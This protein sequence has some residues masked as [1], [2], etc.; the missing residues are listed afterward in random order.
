MVFAAAE[1]SVKCEHFNRNFLT[2]NTEE[3][4]GKQHDVSLYGAGHESK[5]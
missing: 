1:F 5:I 3:K 2:V 4:M